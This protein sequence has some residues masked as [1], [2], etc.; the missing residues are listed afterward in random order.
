MDYRYRKHYTREEARSL[1]P[2]V[3]LWLK[4]IVQLRAELEKYDQRLIALMK[5]GCDLGGESVNSWVRVIAEIKD[6]FSEFNRREIQIKDV[7]RGLID[8]PAVIGGKE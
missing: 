3:R 6:L 5:P 1:L 7:S 8:F 2:Q 4:R